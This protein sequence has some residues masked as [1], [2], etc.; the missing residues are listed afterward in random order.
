MTKTRNDRRTLTG[1]VKSSALDKTVTVVVERTFK[2]PRY[3]KYVRKRK[4]YHAHDEKNEA[5]VGDV[6]E[7]GSIRPLSKLKRWRLARIVQA[8]PDRGVDVQKIADEAQADVGLGIHKAVAEGAGSVEAGPV[9]EGT[10]Q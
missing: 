8:A 2:H 4:K 6:V 9:E 5:G 3:G 10:A 1:V 7:I